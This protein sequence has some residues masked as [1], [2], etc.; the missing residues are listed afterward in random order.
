MAMAAR[1][2]FGSPMPQYLNA[3]TIAT[4]QAI[5]DTGAT[6][7]FIM[8][9]ADVDNKRIAT[10]PLTINLP[11]GKKVVST[12]VC[13]IKIPG[14]VPTMLTGHIIPSLKVASQIGI[15]LL[16][17]AGCKVVFNNE[18][19][20][21][22]FN[23]KVILTEHK[24]P[25]A[26]LWT[27]PTKRLHRRIARNNTPGIVPLPVVINPVPPM[28]APT[29]QTLERIPRLPEGLFNRSIP[30]VAQPAPRTRQR[31]AAP[32]RIQ[33][34]RQQTSTQMAIPSTARQHTITQHAINILTLKEQASFNTIYIPTKLL[35]HELPAH[36]EHCPNPMV[37]PVTG[38]TIFSYKN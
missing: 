28:K 34:D 26:D 25:S 9:G 18:K 17:K 24:D 35:K 7:I 23:N 30:F 33:P 13:D 21:V 2:L 6:S 1:M 8:E 29:A 16:C 22:I 15:R 10:D 4:N 38:E 31:G 37:H 3:I 11:D 5:A 12:H 36:F 27:L 14:L 20:E 32:T 19:C